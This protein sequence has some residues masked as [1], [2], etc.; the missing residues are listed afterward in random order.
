MGP[1]KMKRFTINSEKRYEEQTKAKI[2]KFKRLRNAVIIVH[3]YQRDEIQDIADIT[4]D[5]LAL[6]QA[7]RMVRG[8]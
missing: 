5:S 3:N 4:G 1:I 7:E 6:S 8:W 2:E